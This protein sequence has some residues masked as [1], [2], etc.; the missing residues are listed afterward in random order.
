MGETNKET[1]MK[2][3]ADF[4]DLIVDLRERAWPKFK[5]GL[6]CNRLSDTL[7]SLKA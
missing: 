4:L 2:E 6:N 7:S 3:N 1:E 5:H